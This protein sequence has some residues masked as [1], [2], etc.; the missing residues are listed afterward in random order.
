MLLDLAITIGRI[1]TIY[2]SS[3]VYSQV[4][5]KILHYP[6]KNIWVHELIITCIH[7]HQNNPCGY[8]NLFLL[9]SSI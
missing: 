3:L 9:P 2:F 7:L 6:N 1:N 4:I 8:E 5:E